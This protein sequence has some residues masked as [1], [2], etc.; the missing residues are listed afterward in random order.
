MK[1]FEYRVVEA[2]PAVRM[3]TLAKV[4]NALGS[5]GWELCGFDY[6]C[7]ILKREVMV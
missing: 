1:K 7:M 3:E 2:L 4:L 6:G 5:D